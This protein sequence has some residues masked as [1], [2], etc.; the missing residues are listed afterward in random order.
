M[1][2]P[3]VITLHANGLLFTALERGPAEA[4][5]ILL[6]HGFPDEPDSFRHQIDRFAEVGYRVIAPTMRGYEPSSQP[7]DRDYSLM[8]LADDVIG[9]LDDL[10]IDQAHVVGH[11]WGAAVAYLLGWRHPDRLRSITAMA[12]PPLARIPGA[13]KHVPRQLLRSWYMTWFQT[14]KLAE[15]SLAGRDGWLVHRLWRS[16]SPGYSAP[17]EARASLRW[18]FATAGVIPAALGY[19]RANATPPILLGLHTLAARLS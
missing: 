11:D 13:L 10:G 7:A 15:R 18:R 2:D 17:A 16:W 9:W 8:A 14:P 5:A 6:L 4:P 3:T 1:T 19:Y 12:V